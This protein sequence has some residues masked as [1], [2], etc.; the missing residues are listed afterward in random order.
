[1]SEAEEAPEAPPRP[2]YWVITDE[3]AQALRQRLGQLPRD[4]VNDLV[5]HME[6]PGSLIPVS[7]EQLAAMLGD[8]LNRKTRRAAKKTAGMDM[9]ALDLDKKK[10][11]RK[12]AAKKA[13]TKRRR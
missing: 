3:F 8:G 5:V 9:K 10:A 13:R 4:A 2:P 1:M 7:T 12:K 6:K 11:P